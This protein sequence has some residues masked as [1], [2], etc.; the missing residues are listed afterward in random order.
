MMRLVGGVMAASSLAGSRFSVTGS[1]STSTGTPPCST[2]VLSVLTQVSEVVI[3]S[4]PGC[5]FS[6]CMVISWAVVALFMARQWGTPLYVFSFSSKA[7]DLGPVVIQ[8]LWIESMISAISSS[9]TM[10]RVKG[11]NS[12]RRT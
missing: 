10:G 2:T 6:T 7:A 9:P 5:R 4:S 1:M 8:P 11:R 3:T 12:A